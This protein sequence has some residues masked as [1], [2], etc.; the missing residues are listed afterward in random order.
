MMA[1]QLIVGDLKRAL[2]F[3]FT[4]CISQALLFAQSNSQQNISESE[5]YGRWSGKIDPNMDVEELVAAKDAFYEALYTELNGQMK[6]TGY[7]DYIYWK[8]EWLPRL[9]GSTYEESLKAE[10]NYINQLNE[11]FTGASAPTNTSIEHNWTEI[12]PLVEPETAHTFIR[13]IGRIDHIEFDPANEDRM[14]VC[15]PSG[16]VFFIGRWRHILEHCRNGST[17]SGRRF[18]ARNCSQHKQ[19]KHLVCSHRTWRMV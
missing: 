7:K 2:L 5:Y 17:P 15:S 1:K 19:R 12:G 11:A 13:G 6:K 16:G 9:Q 10:F 14:L 3:F 8:Q 4:V 18:L